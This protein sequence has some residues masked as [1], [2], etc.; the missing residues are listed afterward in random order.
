MDEMNFIAIDRTLIIK[1]IIDRVNEITAIRKNGKAVRQEIGGYFKDLIMRKTLQNEKLQKELSTAFG[2][3]EKLIDSMLS[4]IIG[5]N[6]NE[7]TLEA[8][9]K[10]IAELELTDLLDSLN[11]CSLDDGIIDEIN[12]L[13]S[14]EDEILKEIENR[15]RI[16][17]PL[18]KEKSPMPESI[19]KAM[20]VCYD[21]WED[22][23][24]GTIYEMQFCEEDEYYSTSYEI[25]GN[26]DFIISAAYKRLND[27]LEELN[28]IIDRFNER[29]KFINERKL[30]LLKDI[31]DYSEMKITICFHLLYLLTNYLFQ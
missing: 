16:Y 14:V 6:I 17:E 19:A 2:I 7:E 31:C 30:D 3:R 25:Q 13:L 20:R 28:K 18:T 8:V 15:V 10:A 27:E 9:R 12:D 29:V 1:E 5:E 21:L 22:I 11:T 24:K 23:T 4:L 26:A